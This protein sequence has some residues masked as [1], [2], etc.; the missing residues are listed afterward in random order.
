MTRTTYTRGAFVI[1]RAGLAWSRDSIEAVLKPHD[2][3]IHA[4]LTYDADSSTGRTDLATELRAAVTTWMTP[5]FVG[6]AVAPTAAH[7]QG[8]EDV[9]TRE[10]GLMIADA[11]KH[12]LRRRADERNGR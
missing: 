10:C 7:V 6:I 2:A 4:V 3:P 9:I 11:G 5:P 1:V 12:L 8:I